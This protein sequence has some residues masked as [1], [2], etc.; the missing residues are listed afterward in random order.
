[1]KI[2]CAPEGFNFNSVDSDQE[3]VLYSQSK[4]KGSAGSAV[5]REILKRNLN[6]TARAWDLLS[7]ALSVV[8]SDLAS[9]RTKSPDGWTRQFYLTIAISE[10]SFWSSQKNII[11]K[12]LQFLST[13]VWNLNFIEGGFL[14]QPPKSAEQPIEDAVALLSGGLDSFIGAI[15][16]ISQGIKPYAVS[17]TVR[18]DAV[19]QREFANI[20]GGGLNSI[21]LNHNAKIPRRGSTPPT[22][23]TRSIIFLAYGVLIA[24]CL[25]KFGQGY[26]VPLYMSE[27]GFISINPP[28]T[29]AR[30]GSLSTRT[31]NPVFLQLFQTLLNNA[32][33]NVIVEN[34]YQLKTK[35]EMLSECKNQ[36]LA[37]ANAHSTTSC[38]RYGVH[39]LTHCGRCVPCL[40]RRAAFKNWGKEDQ[41]EY[42]F[43]NLSI[44]DYEHAFYDDVRSARMAIKK[45]EIDGLQSWLGAALSSAVLGDISPYEDVVDRGLLEIKEFLNGFGL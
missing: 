44:Q 29:G 24:S 28:L 17:Q 2:T 15:D 37:I 30:L 12:Q 33:I 27:N 9:P 6:P 35:G 16:L 14:P 20:I 25:E 4:D 32:G 21:Q 13:D 22:Q 45:V 41:T 39:K 34:P 42:V 7:I 10:P 8:A 36:S 26:E 40:I 31:T 19:K 11:E 5:Y 38:G 18:G 3:V 1:M 23:R 43:H